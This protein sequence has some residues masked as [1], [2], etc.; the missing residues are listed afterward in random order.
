MVGKLAPMAE[1][2]PL[3][4]RLLTANYVLKTVEGRSLI[5]SSE[6]AGA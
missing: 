1:F 3:A 4:D 5:G 6:M 2:G